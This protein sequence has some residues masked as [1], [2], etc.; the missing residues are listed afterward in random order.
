MSAR[1]ARR[2]D[3]VVGLEAVADASG[4]AASRLLVGAVGW[5]A[6]AGTPFH[7]VA[8][9]VGRAGGERARGAG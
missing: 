3:E 8:P 7:P 1:G 6:A 9:G 5:L 4:S 2:V